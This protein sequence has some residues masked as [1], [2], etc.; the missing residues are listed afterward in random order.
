MSS[1]HV[2]HTWVHMGEASSLLSCLWH[3]FLSLPGPHYSVSSTYPHSLT[4]H[5]VHFSSPG[6]H[7][8]LQATTSNSVSEYFLNESNS[9]FE[10]SKFVSFERKSTNKMIYCSF[11]WISMNRSVAKS[12]S[13]AF[14]WKFLVHISKHIKMALSPVPFHSISWLCIFR[15]IY[16][17]LTNQ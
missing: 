13:T 12:L 5:Q 4:S 3:I 14:F 15:R 2:P 1:Q 11:I 7:Q 17:T 10:K 16:P 6:M 9:S 8:L